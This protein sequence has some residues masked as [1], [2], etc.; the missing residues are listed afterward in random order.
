MGRCYNCKQSKNYE[1]SVI[2]IM[3]RENVI[4][5]VGYYYDVCE[6]YNKVREEHCD[7]EVEIYKYED[8]IKLHPD[9]IYQHYVYFCNNVSS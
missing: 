8:Y 5:S 1:L 4:C 3:T 6:I 7:L 2:E 9:F